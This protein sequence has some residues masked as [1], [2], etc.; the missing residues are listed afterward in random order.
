MGYGF[1]P[2]I[3]SIVLGIHHVAISDAS[4]P[5]KWTVATVLA[6]SLFIWRYH[7]RWLVVATLLQ[8]AAS[9]YVLVSMRLRD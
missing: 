7:P 8:V 5:S 3:A 4:R 1:I 9:V 2:L 6:A